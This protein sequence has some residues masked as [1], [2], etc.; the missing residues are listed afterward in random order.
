M[1]ISYTDLLAFV[2]QLAPTWNKN[3]HVN[4]TLVL[5]ALL[6]RPTLC[7]SNLAREYPAPS[8][9]LHG[10]LKRLMRFLDNPRLDEGA[11][12]FRWLMLSY[13]FGADPPQSTA[14]PLRLPILLDTTYFEPFAALLATVPC[15]S[16][17]LPIALTTYHRTRL[18]ACFPPRATWPSFE[19]LPFPA[20]HRGQPVCPATSLS[21]EFDSQNQIEEHLLDYVLTM[22]SPGLRAVI[23]ADR[24]FAR[25]S[26]FRWCQRRACD[27]V[28]RMDAQTHIRL[29]A[30]LATDAPTQGPPAQVLGLQPGQRIWC[31]QA[32]YGADDQVPIRLLA[33]WEPGYQEP[34]Y[35]ATCLESADPTET[36][37][38][39]RMRLECTNRDEKTGAILREG[40]DAHQLSSLRHVHRLLLALATLEWLF[41]LIGLQAYHDLPA[42]AEPASP[43]QV[44]AEVES[45][46]LPP[47]AD[48]STLASDPVLP[49][50]AAP[51]AA[52]ADQPEATDPS[53]DGPCLP[54]PVL[55]HRG[56]KTKVPRWMRRFAARGHLSYVRLGL[57]VLRAPDLGHIV[58]H[59]IRW[60]S[61]YLQ[62]WV[63]LWRPWQVRYR[64]KRWWINSS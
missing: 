61:D 63:P 49:M 42:A 16:R 1:G 28:I 14:D 29:P 10:R 44:D 20:R 59:L 41:A 19:H 3:Q 53:Q 32:W 56:T 17:G 24:G 39:W 51:S 45:D 40:G 60:L 31:P 9:S 18:E 23:V 27:F 21:G 47:K 12:F 58:R 62:P 43:R 15:G 50:P 35:L 36:L 26:L 4:L 64:R 54:P 22:L 13:R 25:A 34:W 33:L 30:P 8:Q 52:G 48:V 46:P 37:Y 55:P 6:E 57:E 38:R 5:N 7:L 2:Q 11:L